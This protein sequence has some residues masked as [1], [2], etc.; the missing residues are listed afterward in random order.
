MSFSVSPLTSGFSL[1][2]ST[3]LRE[4]N[5]L[6]IPSLLDTD[7]QVLERWGCADEDVLGKVLLSDGSWSLSLASRNTTLVNGT[8]RIGFGMVELFRKIDDD[9][10]GS[11]F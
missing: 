1:P 7:P 8:H 2:P 6:V 10:G 9:L 5:A 4:P 3:L 11:T